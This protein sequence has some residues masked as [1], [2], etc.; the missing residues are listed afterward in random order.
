MD[1]TTLSAWRRPAALVARPVM[2]PLRRVGLD[3]GRA[4]RNAR[5]TPDELARARAEQLR[6]IR[7]RLPALAVAR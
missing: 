6:Y 7:S 2:Y 1:S 5:P 4:L 3:P